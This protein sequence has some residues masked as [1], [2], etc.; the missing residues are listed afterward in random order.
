MTT[1]HAAKAASVTTDRNVRLGAGL[2]AAA[3]L[4]FVG[5]GIIFLILNFTDQFLELGITEAEVPVGK[6]EITAFSPELFHYI[7]HLHIAIAGMLI[8]I[9]LGVAILAWI[10]V[11]RGLRWAWWTAVALPVITLAI[12]LPAHYPN[13]FDTAGHL[14]LI[15][16][17]TAIFVGG[18]LL[19]LTVARPNE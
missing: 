11:R 8:A 16:V 13:N 14:G 2:M 12:A 17:A 18:A 6:S 1:A 5:Y 4:G 15:Y 19:S 3:G 7:S 10:G 9:G